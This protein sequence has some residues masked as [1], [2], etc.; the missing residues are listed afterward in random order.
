MRPVVEW[1]AARVRDEI[2]RLRT[3]ELDVLE[4]PS[5]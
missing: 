3:M 5:D 4:A 1:L 2:K